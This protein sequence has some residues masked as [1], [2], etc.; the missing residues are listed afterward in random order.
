MSDRRQTEIDH[1][2]S[3]HRTP[4]V[5]GSME[6][7]IADVVSAIRQMRP[8]AAPGLDDIPVSVLKEN[9][10]IIAPWLALIYT[11]SLSLH[12]FPESWKTA[13]VIPLKKPGKSS[14][15]TPCSYRLI[16][17]LSHIGKALERIVNQR[18]MR[19]L[20]S[21]CLLSPFQF[22]FSAYRQAVS[23]CLRITED[24]Y[25]AFRCGQQVQAVA[26]DL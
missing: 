14:H 15:S 9:Q 8:K 16:S 3:T 24:I 21:R 22:G 5:P 25:S 18:L 1:T 10:F 19:Q 17:L 26:L 7:S 12:Y 11:A 20:E 6:V 13:K 4:G 2:W 23:A